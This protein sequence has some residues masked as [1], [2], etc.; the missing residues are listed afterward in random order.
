VP[1]PLE[2]FDLRP[3][4]PVRDITLLVLETPGDDDEEVAL[5]DPEAFL[6]L[7]LDPPHP[8]DAIG[9]PD[10]DMVGTKHRFGPCEDLLVSFSR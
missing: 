8:G 1:V 2:P 4:I 5:A 3:G 7:A 6:D 9:A 10:R